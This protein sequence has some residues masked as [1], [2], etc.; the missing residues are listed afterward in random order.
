LPVL[1]DAQAADLR[2]QRL[3]W[4]PEFRGRSG[5]PGYPAMAFGESRFDHKLPEP[6]LIEGNQQVL[7][8]WG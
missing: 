4:N 7:I 3:P 5:R 1:I 8:K 2:L 6:S